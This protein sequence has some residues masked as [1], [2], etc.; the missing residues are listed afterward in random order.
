MF[1]TFTQPVER[2]P[3]EYVQSRRLAM[4]PSSPWAREASSRPFPSPTWWAGVCHDGPVSSSSS[5][6]ARRSS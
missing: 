4:M 3:G 2:R 1:L 5:S 6:F